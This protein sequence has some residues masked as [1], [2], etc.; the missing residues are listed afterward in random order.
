M[1]GALR[2]E[3]RR[4]GIVGGKRGVDEEV[5]GAGVHEQL[6]LVGPDRG[7]QFAGSVDVALV[8]EEL[9]VRLAVDLNGQVLGPCAEGVLAGNREARF[10][11]ECATRAGARLGEPLCS[12][13]TPRNAGIH[14]PLRQRLCGTVSLR[15]QCVARLANDGEGLVQRG[16]RAPVEQIWGVDGVPRLSQLVGERSHSLG[17]PLDVVVQHDLGHQ[18]L[19]TIDP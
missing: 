1:Q 18:S 4:V 3:C 14:Q 12:A 5:L 9:V 16:E 15:V 10:I 7:D 17:Q 13:D 6:G 19:P 2:H 11:E 8:R